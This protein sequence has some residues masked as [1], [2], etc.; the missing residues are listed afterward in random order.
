MDINRKKVQRLW[1]EEAPRTEALDEEHHAED[2]LV[3]WQKQDRRWT[4]RRSFQTLRVNGGAACAGVPAIAASVAGVMSS[5]SD[6]H[7]GI[8]CKE[9]A[10]M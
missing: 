6:C 10:D 5:S 7:C 2:V 8:Q 9:Y 4:L 1:R 3:R